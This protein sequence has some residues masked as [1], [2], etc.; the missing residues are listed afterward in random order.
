MG[1]EVELHLT[2]TGTTDLGSQIYR[3]LRDAV[4]DGRLRPGEQLPPTRELA[5]HLAVSRNTVA[6]A[7]DRL[8]AEGF[9]AARMGAGTYVSSQPAVRPARRSAPVGAISP[10]PAFRSITASV[11]SAEWTPAYDLRIGI[12]DGRLFPVQTWRR[13]LSRQLRTSMLTDGT[14]RDPGGYPSLRA[15]IARHVGAARSVRASADDVLV[16]HG[17]QQAVDLITRVLVEPGSCVAIEDPG[18]PPVRQLLAAAGARVV[19]V[20]VDAEGLVV[21][22]LPRTARLVYTTPSHQFPM[23][24][25]MSLARRR[26]LV[27]WAARH[28]AAIIEDDYDTEFRYCER[29]LEPLQALDRHGRVIYVGTFSKTLLPLLRIGY[30]VAPSSLRPALLAAKQLSDWHGDIPTQAALAGFLADGLLARHIRKAGAVYGERRTALVAGVDRHLSPWFALQPSMA[31]LHVSLLTRPRAP[32]DI[33]RLV[34]RA[35]AAGVGVQSLEDFAVESEQRGLVLG[36][37]AIESDR[38][39][40]GLKILARLLVDDGS[41]P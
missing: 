25:A 5:Q 3:Q 31:G 28:Q 22:A 36:F 18:Y 14:Y 6:G 27:E 26:A 10:R 2:V 34:R 1:R 21:E 17:T 19:A 29:P 20:P 33:E 11:T 41:S 30:L 38:I 39:E 37:G 9:L 35:A 7:Y 15:E 12:P 13:Q 16:T 24:V 8:T 40:S 4:V 32:L 23:G